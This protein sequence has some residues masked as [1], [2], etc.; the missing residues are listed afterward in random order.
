MR[1]LPLGMWESG[2]P[3]FRSCFLHASHLLPSFPFSSSL[4]RLPL[5]SLS[6]LPSLMAILFH[7]SLMVA[8]LIFPKTMA[9]PIYPLMVGRLNHRFSVMVG[10][11]SAYIGL[12]IRLFSVFRLSI[13]DF[14]Y[15]KL[16]PKT[17]K[18]PNLYT[19]LSITTW[20]R[21]GQPSRKGKYGRR[22]HWA[23]KKMSHKACDVKHCATKE[24]ASS[25]EMNVAWNKEQR[26]TV[27]C[28][29]YSERRNWGSTTR[30]LCDEHKAVVV[31]F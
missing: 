7:L 28:A 30:P 31:R 24:S 11:R 12:L 1:P 2:N 16:A 10:L 17:Y 21:K 3:P 4:P 14:H 19:L 25:R 27:R 6:C 8:C 29:W 26:I 23:V 18:I 15:T 20:L 5:L 13:G 9:W 22:K